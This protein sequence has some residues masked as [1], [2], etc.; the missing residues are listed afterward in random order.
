MPGSNVRVPKVKMTTLR[1]TTHV[2]YIGDLAVVVFGKDAMS[3]SSLTGRQ[4]GAHKDVECKPSLDEEKLEAVI[5]EL[6]NNV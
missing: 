1:T 4:S 6:F 2:G 3:T 5:G